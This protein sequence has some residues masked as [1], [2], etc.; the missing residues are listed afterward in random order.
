MGDGKSGEDGAGKLIMI[1]KNWF[2]GKRQMT[3]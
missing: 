3:A 2:I 1:I